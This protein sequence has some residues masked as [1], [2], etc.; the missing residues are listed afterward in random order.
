MSLIFEFI[1]FVK[2]TGTV[3][4]KVPFIHYIIS[5]YIAVFFKLN[6][7]QNNKFVTI[8]YFMEITKPR[9]VG[10]LMC[11]NNHLFFETTRTILKASAKLV[12]ICVPHLLAIISN[13]LVD[14]G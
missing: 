5:I 6:F 13:A 1:W 3:N 7:I 4:K 9:D 2:F 12:P 10:R 11:T 14:L 8:Y